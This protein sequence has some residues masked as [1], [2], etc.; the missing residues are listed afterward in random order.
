M[1]NDRGKNLDQEILNAI[2]SEVWDL[3]GNPNALN[4]QERKNFIDAVTNP[5]NEFF[6]LETSKQIMADQ[7]Y[8]GVVKRH[9][10]YWQAQK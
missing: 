1:L 3:D 5:D 10:D 6:N 8:N 2:D 7:I 4:D 9:Q